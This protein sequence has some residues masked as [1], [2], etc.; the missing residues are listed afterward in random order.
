MGYKGRALYTD[1]DMLNF[2]D[3]SALYKTDL[4]GKAWYVWMLCKIMVRKELSRIP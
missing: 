4:E 3:I 2:R 1:V